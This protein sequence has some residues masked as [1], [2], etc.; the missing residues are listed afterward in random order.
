MLF[1]SFGPWVAAAVGGPA[2][3]TY[4]EAPREHAAQLP[5]SLP[6]RP[7]LL[8]GREELLAGLDA[9]LRAGP[10]T[11]RRVVALYGL[12]V[13]ARRAWRWSTRTGI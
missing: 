8:A 6:P 10:G 5:V 4:A 9:R 7:T 2:I 13:R 3:G 11:G 12:G 1:R